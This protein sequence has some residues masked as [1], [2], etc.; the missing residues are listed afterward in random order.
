MVVV[1]PTGYRIAAQYQRLA[2][3]AIQNQGPFASMGYETTSNEKECNTM[4]DAARS[5][6]EVRVPDDMLT[7]MG[8]PAASNMLD[9]IKA[10][11]IAGGV[12]PEVVRAYD[13]RE[14]IVRPGESASPGGHIT[15]AGK[16]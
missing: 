15:F 12:E 16:R 3:L 1:T 8:E 6:S 7:E 11:F 14:W 5:N 9:Q 2:R 13:R 10:S 4:S